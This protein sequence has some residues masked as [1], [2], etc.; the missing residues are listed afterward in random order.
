MTIK[1][2][3][4]TAAIALPLLILLLAFAPALLFVVF[5]ALVVFLAQLEFNRMGLADQDPLA[6]WFS[7]FAGAVLILVVY[8][9]QGPAVVVF[10]ALVFLLLAS[11]YLFFPQSL[12]SLPQRLG[13]LCLG[14]IYIAVLLAHLVPLRLLD[15]GRQWIFLVLVAVMCCDTSAY[16]VGSRFGKTKLYPRISPNKSVEGAVGGVGGAVIGALAAK[17]VFFSVLSVPAA[18]FIGLV[19]GV[20]GQVGD[21]FESMLKR[22]CAVKDSG[23]M[24]PG[25]GGLLDRLDS[26]LFAFPLTYYIAYFIV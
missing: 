19:L 25:H 23:T 9:G 15:D 3:L 17:V 7:A 16:V 6:R 18:V 8:V 26:L 21:L 1:Q 14:L 11:L 5:L 20:V 22:A 12:S 24:I 2:R 4:I 10:L 13:W